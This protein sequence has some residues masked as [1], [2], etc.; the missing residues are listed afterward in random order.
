MSKNEAK[1]ESPENGKKVSFGC[2]RWDAW[3]ENDIPGSAYQQSLKCM[4][5]KKFNDCGYWPWWAKLDENGD[6]VSMNENTEEIMIMENQYAYDAGID[7]W[8]FLKYSDF[9]VDGNG[10]YLNEQFLKY[11]NSPN[12]DLVKFC[13]I[14][15]SRSET[16]DVMF[17]RNT[18]YMKDPQYFKVLRGRPLVYIWCYGIKDLAA[19]IT[20][21]RLKI[22]ETCGSDPYIVTYDFP[23]NGED[24]SSS[25]APG[26]GWGSHGAEYKRLITENQ[27]AWENDIGK[28]K[29]YV[30]NATNNWDS[31]PYYENP[32]SWWE[33]PSDNWYIAPAEDE[34]R[35]MLQN[36]IDFVLANPEK[37]PA[38]TI[39]SKE[40]NGFTE[41]GAIAPSLKFGTRFIMGI[42]SVDKSGRKR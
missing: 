2:M 37:C 17:E 24:A 36:G 13:F 42:K 30:P 7:Y 9:D 21:L 23:G 32:P 35:E 18:G 19:F 15:D 28:Y 25:Y 1:S 14:L 29:N 41:G 6:L 16:S 33:K 40:W 34:Y 11:M 5:N 4:Q 22:R 20:K 12:K 3:A 8:A 26:L 27:A 39:C 10:G 31:R 38:M